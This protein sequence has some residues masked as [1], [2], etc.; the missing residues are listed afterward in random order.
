MSTYSASDGAELAYDLAGQ[1][2]PLLC[3]PGG[4][5][6]DPIYMEGLG[7]LAAGRQLIVLHPRGAGRS[8]QSSDPSDYGAERLAQDSLDLAEHLGED[9]VDLLGHSAGAFAAVIAAT[10]QR[11]KVRRVVLV[12]P[13]RMLAPQVPDDTED[14]LAARSSEPWYDEVQNALSGANP[15]SAAE[16]IALVSKVSPA[17]YGGWDSARQRHAERLQDQ[18]NLETMENTP[19]PP[20]LK[21]KPGELNLNALVITGEQDAASGTAIGDPIADFFANGR[22]VVMPRCGH[23]PWVDEPKQFVSI[24]DSFL[25]AD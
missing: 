25:N 10:D 19:D 15:E 1:G 6:R 22:H 9:Q 23:Y 17:F 14:I 20:A 16:M 12:A 5:G 3:I 11:A 4:P 18:V 7:G 13:T 21:L 24:I 2:A 8:S